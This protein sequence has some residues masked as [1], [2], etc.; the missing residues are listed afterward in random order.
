MFTTGTDAGQVRRIADQPTAT[1]ISVSPTWG[2]TPSSGNNFIIIAPTGSATP[3]VTNPTATVVTDTAR[4]FT[5]GDLINSSLQLTGQDPN[6]GTVTTNGTNIR[7]DQV[8]AITANTATSITVSPPFGTILPSNG[9]RYLV[10]RGRTTTSPL[11]SVTTPA[12]LTDSA[13]AFPDFAGFGTPWSVQMTTGNAWRQSMVITASTPPTV[14][15]LAGAWSP[16]V[17]TGGAYAITASGTGASHNTNTSLT[18][19]VVFKL[20]AVQG[21]LMVV[22]AG[23]GA[24]TDRVV[25]GYTV[26]TNAGTLTVAPAWATTSGSGTWTTR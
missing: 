26:G 15:T 2:N 12:T 6:L 22:T 1:Q 7:N 5:P 8:R 21:S 19:N 16:N 18:D 4:N 13:A 25:T 20:P 14:L 24:P 11:A 23:T 9:V 3:P 17:P 10:Y